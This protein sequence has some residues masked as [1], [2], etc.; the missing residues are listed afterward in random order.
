MIRG[1]AIVSDVVV[2]EGALAPGRA[3]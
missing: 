3:R 2:I 1:G